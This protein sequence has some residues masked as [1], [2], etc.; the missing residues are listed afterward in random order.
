MSDQDFPGWHGTTI[1]GVR[2]NGEVVIAVFSDA[3][4]RRSMP[5]GKVL[6]GHWVSFRHLSPY[7]GWTLAAQGSALGEGLL[8]VC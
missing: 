2:K 5:S 3:D 7:G 4:D 8:Q 6:I 1:I